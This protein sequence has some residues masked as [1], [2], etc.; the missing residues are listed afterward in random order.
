MND[1]EQE[2]ANAIAQTLPDGPTTLPTTPRR[3]FRLAAWV[4]CAT[5]NYEPRENWSVTVTAT[6]TK[7]WHRKTPEVVVATHLQDSLYPGSV[8]PLTQKLIAQLDSR[9]H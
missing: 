5:H 3:W 6:V 4:V 2:I 8:E 9:A 7:K 1:Q